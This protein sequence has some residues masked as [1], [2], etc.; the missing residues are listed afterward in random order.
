MKHLTKFINES[1]NESLQDFNAE[2]KNVS[3]NSGYSLKDWE[4]LINGLYGYIKDYKTQKQ[5]EDEIVDEYGNVSWS[6]ALVDNTNDRVHDDAIDLDLNDDLAED[7]GGEIVR[8]VYIKK[9]MEINKCD[10][11]KA[12]EILN[13]IIENI[14]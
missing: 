10:Y 4:S 8:F 14:N 6:D 5:I 1:I 11:N 2:L 12:N 13:K 3:K 9:L 7:Y